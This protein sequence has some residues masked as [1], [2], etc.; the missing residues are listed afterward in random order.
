MLEEHAQVGIPVQCSGLV[1]PR[2]LLEA[3]ID[4]KA[5]F[6]AFMGARIVSPNGASYEIGGDRI[7]AYVLDRQQFDELLAQQALE[8]GVEQWLDTRVVSLA[9]DAP[10]VRLTAGRND[11]S[12]SFLTRLVIGADG[13]RSIVAS[14]LRLPSP[15]EIVRARSVDVRLPRRP[16][17][18]Q[19]CIFTGERYGPGFFAWVIPVGGDRYRIGWGIGR[20]AIR[21]NPLQALVKDHPEIF[22]GLEILSQTG[23]LIPLGARSRMSGTRGLVVGD[24]AGQAKATSGGGLYTSLDSARH[25]A[26][27]AI[28]ALSA[29][30]TSAERLNVYDTSWQTGIGR[31]I[32][33]AMALR[34]AYRGLTD[35]ELEW[36]LQMLR[37]P[38][39]R[40]VVDHYGDI[41]YPSWLARK[42][43]R[44]APGLLHLLN[45]KSSPPNYQLETSDVHEDMADSPSINQ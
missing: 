37:V 32:T 45:D 23:G 35:R 41:D 31:E 24:A 20:P 17:T 29:D 14:F 27:A 33:Q 30:D 5:A 25:C 44:I 42:A 28:A 1:S 18:D 11:S 3:N 13:P 16:P 21:A 40:Q 43:L 2:T 19:V 9:L 8:A 39:M 26:D 22:E 34:A 12:R 10:G 38:G 4:P 15:A 6:N 36:A 7:H